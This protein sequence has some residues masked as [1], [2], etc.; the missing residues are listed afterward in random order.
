MTRCVF[1]KETLSFM[2]FDDEERCGMFLEK[3]VFKATAK[4]KLCHFLN[5][6]L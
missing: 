6:K 2:T 4:M 1:G 3:A 5:G